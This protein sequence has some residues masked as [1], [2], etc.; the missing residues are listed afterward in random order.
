MNLPNYNKLASFMRH[1]DTPNEP[2]DIILYIDT[3]NNLKTVNIDKLIRPSYPALFESVENIFGMDEYLS[4]CVHERENNYWSILALKL[5]GTIKLACGGKLLPNNLEFELINT[6][7]ILRIE[8]YMYGFYVLDTNYILHTLT[9]Y[10]TEQGGR[11]RRPNTYKNMSIERVYD[12]MKIYIVIDTLIIVKGDD[13]FRIYG[14]S[15]PI[16]ITF[17]EDLQSVLDYTENSITI[18]QDYVE[19]IPIYVIH[20]NF[21]SFDKIKSINMINLYSV[22]VLTVDNVLYIVNFSLAKLEISVSV[23]NTTPM[24]TSNITLHVYSCGVDQLPINVVR[25]TEFGNL[26]LPDIDQLYIF[27]NDLIQVNVSI[28]AITVHDS[29]QDF[30]YIEIGSKTFHTHTQIIKVFYLWNYNLILVDDMNC[31]HYYNYW[32]N[33]ILL[34]Y[35]LEGVQLASD[36]YFIGI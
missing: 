13:I 19:S 18:V 26:T 36:D 25:S 24:M 15:S 4:I 12:Y 34:D 23:I 7:S 2:K 1:D 17:N 28:H 31:I 29:L 27:K 21:I 3:L 30:P 11:R 33:E 5:D 16:Y 32:R 14:E 20:F 35:C 9:I 8:T 10:N 6:K 22:N